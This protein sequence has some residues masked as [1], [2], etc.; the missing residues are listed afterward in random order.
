[1]WSYKGLFVGI[2]AIFITPLPEISVLSKT[3][4]LALL[5]SCW[6][7]IWAY[8]NR[9]RKIRKNKVGILICISCEDVSLNKQ[10]KE[11]LIN[12]LR[13]S[14]VSGNINSF[15]DILIA[16]SHIAKRVVTLENGKKLLNDWNGHLLIYGRVKKRDNRHQLKVKAYVRHASLSEESHKRFETEISSA[17]AGQYKLENAEKFYEQFEITSKLVS[18]SSKYILGLAAFASSDYHMSSGIFEDVKSM[19]PK[20]KREYESLA[21]IK[22]IKVGTTRYLN[23]TYLSNCNIELRRWNNTR[24]VSCMHNIGVLLSKVYGAYTKDA[25]YLTLKAIVYVVKDNDLYQARKA[26]E[27]IKNKFRD[28]LWHLNMGFIE[29]CKENEN[30]L[31]KQYSKAIELNEASQDE[32]KLSKISELEEFICWYSVLNKAPLLNF[33]LGLLNE[34]FKGDF[35]K[36]EEDYRE[37]ATGVEETKKFPRALNQVKKFITK[38]NEMVLDSGSR[39][40]QLDS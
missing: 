7:L 35:V 14:L 25:G 21:T 23:S 22:S 12:E 20:F 36:A 16:P 2:I 26:L 6:I 28:V 27:N 19:L 13:D 1:M 9:L 17:W 31:L 8:K 4:L 32:L 11:D 37:F 24:S 33:L 38:D 10:I 18:L 34:K 39:G 29:A 15:A 40:I 5:I 30:G 3:P